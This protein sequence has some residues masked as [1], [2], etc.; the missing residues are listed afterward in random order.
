MA[1]AEADG[2]GVYTV[3]SFTRELIE[4]VRHDRFH[5]KPVWTFLSRSWA[6]SVEDIWDVPARFRSGSR[7]S[8]LGAVIGAA[9]LALSA[10][11]HPTRVALGAS[12]LWLLWYAATVF[13][14]LTHLGMVDDRNGRPYGR[15]LW[16]NGM[17]FL[18][19][20][21]APLVMWPCLAAPSRSASPPRATF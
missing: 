7:W 9:V 1:D 5:P 20:G 19:L 13:F 11:V 12:G 15:L 18:R 3:S 2:D 17:S 10:P 14:V 6:R 21:L 16:P 8:V 4:D